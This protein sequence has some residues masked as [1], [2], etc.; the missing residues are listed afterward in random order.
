MSDSDRRKPNEESGDP[1]KMSRQEEYFEG[2][3]QSPDQGAFQREGLP[4]DYRMRYEEDHYVDEL[5]DAGGMPQLRLVPVSEIE[6]GFG[7]GGESLDGLID[8]IQAYGVLQ[9]LLVRR[10]RG[11]YELLAG[12]K[13]LAAAV[14][15]GLKEVPCLVHEVDDVEAR[16]LAEAANRRASR[17]SSSLQWSTDATILVA[18]SLNTILST[19]GLLDKPDSS[20]R[21][22]VAVG[23]I[24]A[25]ALRANR[26]MRG[27]EILRAEPALT[28]R[29]I[30]AATI[31][32][33]VL[34]AS[35][36]ERG[37]LGIELQARG[38]SSCPI[39]ADEELVAV[40]ISG[41][42]ET[43]LALMRSGRGGR[44]SVDM[45][46]NEL[47][48]T[49][50][51][52]VSEDAVRMPTSSWSHWFDPHWDERPGGFGAAVSLLAA[53][54]AAEL[55]NGRLEIAPTAAGGCRLT[56]MLPTDAS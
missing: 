3:T 34:T 46:L 9:P 47:T 49:V 44:L 33:N 51:L 16:R 38:L 45:T 1:N 27:L 25:E 23:L 50:N 4:D 36:D 19:L 53:K 56:M 15:A 11:R 6:G 22:R 12:S 17:T 32:K 29:P 55:H 14:N 31:L 18:G 21:D 30:D 42:I 48:N 2:A 43:I 39:R 7:S 40:A 10:L 20:L 26:L 8:S 13:R 52:T 24:R 54:R 28:R 35:E 5:V 37:L 41:A